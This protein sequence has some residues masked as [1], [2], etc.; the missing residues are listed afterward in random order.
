MHK[1][2]AL[3]SRAL[4]L[5]AAGYV[6]KHNPYPVLSM[7]IDKVQRG[8]RFV[9]PDLVDGLLAGAGGGK[10]KAGLS[11]REHQILHLIADGKPLKRIAHELGIDPKTVTSHKTRLMAKLGLKSNAELIR[12]AFKNTTNTPAS[13]NVGP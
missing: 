9:D 12:Y 2:P 6:C 10:T 13:A 4:A 5:G 8:R 3:A 1:D 7:A 11:S